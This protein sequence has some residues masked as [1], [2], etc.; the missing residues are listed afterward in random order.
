SVSVPPPAPAGGSAR[1]KDLCE[2]DK[3][4]FSSLVREVLDLKRQTVELSERCALLE[5]E[6]ETWIVERERYERE[7]E[8]ERDQGASEQASV[9][10][11]ITSLR[12]VYFV[13]S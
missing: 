6:K 12:Y 3:A 10:A 9:L 4:K 5:R 2:E 1:I 13:D 11:E 7:R 8:R